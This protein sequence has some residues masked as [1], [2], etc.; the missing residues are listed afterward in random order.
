M[1]MALYYN[2]YIPNT[3]FRRFIDFDFF[4]VTENT[5]TGSQNK[6]AIPHQPCEVYG[7][8]FSI[9]PLM[10]GKMACAKLDQSIHIGINPETGNK[11]YMLLEIV[12]CRINCLVYPGDPTYVATM[13]QFFLFSL[14]NPAHYISTS[15]LNNYE[16]PLT[17]ING[18]SQHNI[19]GLNFHSKKSMLI[20][21]IISLTDD[22]IFLRSK[23]KHFGA[24]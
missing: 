3:P 22:G 4:F 15:D 17:H 1:L 11:Q 12:P 9:D 20:K 8:P 6:I 18:R 2:I 16:K 19:L 14:V 5:K 13:A 10:M 23:R 24:A 21:Q 7:P